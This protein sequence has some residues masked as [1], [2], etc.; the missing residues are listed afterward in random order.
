MVSTFVRSAT[1]QK[2]WAL[3]GALLTTRAPELRAGTVQRGERAIQIPCPSFLIQHER[4]L[5]LFDTGVS[6]KGIADPGAYY[7][8]LAARL[9]LQFTPDLAVDAQLGGLGY[10]PAQVRFVIPSHLHFDHAGGLYLF[11]DATFLLGAGE[12]PYAYWPPPSQRATFVLED[13]VP[14]RGFHWVELPGD[15]DLFGDGSVAILRTPGHTPGEVSLL[16]R[17]PNRTVILTGDTCHYGLEL[18]HGMTV[19]GMVSADEWQASASIRRLQLIRD[20]LGAE[21]WINH[22]P[23][24]WAQRPHAPEAIT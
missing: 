1:A 12:M 14:I 8:E 17:L 11:P 6:P 16:V 18:E 2:L 15:H 5:V 19:A 24:H 13:L 3:P 21:V 4:G 23:E 7:G 9:N 22:D 10:R 20:G